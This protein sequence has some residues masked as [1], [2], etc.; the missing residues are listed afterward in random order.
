MIQKLKVKPSSFLSEETQ[1][2]EHRSGALVNFSK[3]VCGIIFRKTCRLKFKANGRVKFIV[4][5]NMKIKFS[6]NFD[7]GYDGH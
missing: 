5:S 1:T 3:T 6:W 2:S 7:L 4:I